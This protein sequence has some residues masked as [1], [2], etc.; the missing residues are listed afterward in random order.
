VK[1]YLHF[2]LLKNKKMRF[3]K[4]FFSTNFIIN[5]VIEWYKSTFYVMQYIACNK[6]FFFNLK[7]F[8]YADMPM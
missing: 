8:S 1:E 5:K 6:I 3:N 4:F 7:W 2:V